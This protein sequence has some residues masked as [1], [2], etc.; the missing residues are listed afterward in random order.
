MTFAFRYLPHNL[1]PMNLKYILSLVLV[2]LALNACEQVDQKVRPVDSKVKIVSEPLSLPEGFP[3][4]VVLH[5]GVS[6]NDIRIGQGVVND[7]G[8]GQKIYKSFNIEKINP[9]MRGD[10]VSHYQQ[11]LADNGWE[12]SWTLSEDKR[13][14]KGTFTRD[15]MELFI[16]INDAVFFL[17]LKVFNG[18]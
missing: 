14:G 9:K 1:K 13:D 10:I 8:Q 6:A 15:N 16:K 17:K 5:E 12:G 4:S 3:Q 7:D 18:S 11:V 2:A